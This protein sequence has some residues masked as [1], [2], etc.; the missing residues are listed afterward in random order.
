MHSKIVS[1]DIS[2]RQTDKWEQAISD[3]KSNNQNKFSQ[4]NFYY[5]ADRRTTGS[6]LLETQSVGG[7]GR[8][9]SIHSSDGSRDQY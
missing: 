9:N 8:G 1:F 2:G 6:V 4:I 7:L 3:T 5:C